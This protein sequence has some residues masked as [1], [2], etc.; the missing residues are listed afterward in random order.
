MMNESGAFLRYF[1]FIAYMT[2]GLPLTV[3]HF[4][5]LM[6]RAVAATT[7][8]E[9]VKIFVKGMGEKAIVI[10]TD[11]DKEED[12]RK[13]EFR[14]IL[15]QYFDLE[16]IASFLVGA[17]TFK[18]LAPDQKE[19]YMQLLPDYIVQLYLS[20]FEEYQTDTMEKHDFQVTH[21]IQR[22]KDERAGFSADS[23][24]KVSQENGSPISLKV[25][26]RVFNTAKG[27]RIL[28]VYVNDL[29]MSQTKKEEFKGI[30]K[31]GGIE[32]L[33]EQLSAKVED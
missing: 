32:A 23:T 19:R 3:G 9:Q 27:L 6:N 31:Q 25:Q 2:I 8:T 1:K 30:L 16:G 24:I 29:S 26:W 22:G 4:S 12:A 17:E 21:T 14:D 18:S 20:K 13:R 33:L 11:R 7:T 10:L 15:N 5:P 28:D